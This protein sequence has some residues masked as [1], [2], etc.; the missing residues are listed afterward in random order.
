MVV[1]IETCLALQ[2]EFMEGFKT[3][4]SE[5]SLGTYECCRKPFLMEQ[6]DPC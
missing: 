1:V 6:L 2:S 5:D 3:V 4:E